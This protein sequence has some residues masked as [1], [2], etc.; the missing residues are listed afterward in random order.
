MANFKIY[1][2]EFAVRAENGK[3]KSENDKLRVEV[4]RL[5][6]MVGE[7]VTEKELAKIVAIQ[8]GET[9]QS[10]ECSVTIQPAKGAGG[11]APRNGGGG[12]REM[13]PMVTRARGKRPAGPAVPLGADLPASTQTEEQETEA[14]PV[15]IRQGH[16]PANE[17]DSVDNSD[18]GVRFRM[19]E[20]R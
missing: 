13:N 3:L 9:F 4:L 7:P 6:Q 2:S 17:A 5:K 1:Q 15:V 19:I 8:P 12:N 20:L 16:A 14:Q 18:A 10:G 11:T